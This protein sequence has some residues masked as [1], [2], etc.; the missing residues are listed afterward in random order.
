MLSRVANS[1]Y[2][3]V[4]Y[5]ER[6]DNLARLIEVNERVLLDFGSDEGSREET[7]W[8]PI[9]A[10]TGDEE[11]YAELNP[12]GDGPGS[13]VHFLT[14]DR[15]NPNSIVSC[16][17][18]GREN[19]RMVRDQL[20]EALW[21]EINSLYLFVNSDAAQRMLSSDRADYFSAIRRSTFCFHGIAAGT[22]LRREAWAFMELGRYLERA[23]KTTRFLDVAYFLPP[24]YAASS[25]HWMSILKSCGALDAYRTLN[26]GPV[27]RDGVVKFLLFEKSFPRSVAFSIDRVDECLHNISG[28]PRGGYG[29]A[30]ERC[31]G[32]LL[33]ELSFSDLTAIAGDGLHPYLDELQSGINDVGSEVFETYVL[34]PD[35]AEVKPSYPTSTVSAVAAWQMEQ[36]Q[37]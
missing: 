1:L 33:S 26:R 30:A 34:L 25:D 16:I 14:S 19:A 20:S 24:E 22:T 3:M 27:D 10:S 15:K 4:R 12:G 6:A 17:A 18:L 31:S 2:W 21:E 13:V 11:L 28:R 8:R 37:Q 9:I 5:I 35:K 7:F 23:D 32:K 29:D 36:Q